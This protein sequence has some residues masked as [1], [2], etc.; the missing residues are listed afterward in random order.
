MLGETPSIPCT[1]F[2][3]RGVAA[4][5]NDVAPQAQARAFSFSS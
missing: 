3:G 1:R 2:P 5:E 4:P